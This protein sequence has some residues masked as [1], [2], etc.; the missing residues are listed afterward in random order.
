ML[1][2]GFRS[3]WTAGIL[4]IFLVLLGV[5]R[6]LV[7]QPYVISSSSMEPTL[8][9]GD[10]V[11]VNRLAYLNAAPSRGDIIVFAYPKDPKRTFVKR[12]IAVPGETVELRG[13]QVF[14]DGQVLRE[15]YL[16]AGDYPPYGPETVPRGKVLVLGDNRRQSEDSRAWGLLPQS[17]IIGKVWLTY[18]PFQR[19]RFF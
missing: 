15:P 7:I 17:A 16:K 3:W 10:R 1:R 5:V 13:N 18:F 6:W 4:V 8:R 2:Q 14:I 11:L 19:W 12:V 9:S